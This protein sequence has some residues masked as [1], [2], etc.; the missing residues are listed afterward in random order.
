MSKRIFG[1]VVGIALVGLAIG[2]TLAPNGCS[3]IGAGGNVQL[4]TATQL[5]ATC[6]AEEKAGTASSKAPDCIAYYAIQQGCNVAA[7]GTA[8]NPLVATVNP[9]A[10]SI[11]TTAA[12]ISLATCQ[13]QGFI[14]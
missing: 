12:D 11:L 10:G 5:L 1:I 3:L 13:K 6:Q 7:L 8:V 2:F 9:V 14:S 4:P